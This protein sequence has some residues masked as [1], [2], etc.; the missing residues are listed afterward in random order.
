MAEDVL[1]FLDECGLDDVTLVGHSM[2]GMVAYLVAIQQPHRVERLVVEDAP[3]PYRRR[4]A[5]SPD[6][7]DGD[8]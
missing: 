8:C 2:G 5:C 4:L 3:P 1:G 7:P 6:R